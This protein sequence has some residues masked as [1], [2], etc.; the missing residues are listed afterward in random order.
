[1]FEGPRGRLIAAALLAVAGLGVYA[2]SLHGPFVFDDIYS[3]VEDPSLAHLWPPFEARSGSGASGRPLV[4]LTLKLNHALGGLEVHGYHLLNVVLHVLTSWTLFGFARRALART[5]LADVAAGTGF[6]IALL[7]TVHPL[8]SD[9]LN[10]VV[11][12]SEVLLGLF[13]LLTLYATDRALDAERP[14]RW[15]VLG[16]LACA[17]AMASKEIA[18]SLP[19]AALA[20]ERTF[21]SGSFSASWRARRGYYLGLGATWAVLGL[22]LG[23]AERGASVGFGGELSSLDYLR[24]QAGGLLHYLRLSFW[25]VGLSADYFGWAPVRSWGPALAP[26]LVVAFL[27]TLSL[28]SFLKGRPAGWVGLVALAIL[29]PSSSFL[30]I[31][32]EWL[33]EHRMYLPLAAVVALAVTGLVLLLRGVAPK[34]AGLVGTALCVLAAIPLALMT[35]GRNTTWSDAEALWLDTLARY[36]ENARAHDSLAVLYLRS[37][38]Y[39][40]AEAAAREAQRLAPQLVA[41]D[42][43]LATALLM[44]DRAAEALPYY[45]RAR[46]HFDGDPRFHA[47]YGAALSKTPRRAE[48]I[49][50]LRRAL[51]QAPD[52]AQAHR[53]LA[54]T[55]LAEDRPLEALPHL[56]RLLELAPDPWAISTTIEL[57]ASHPDARVRNGNEALR[58]AERL[59]Q[60]GARDAKAL[61]LYAMSLAEVGRFEEAVGAVS[62]AIQAAPPERPKLMESLRARRARYAERQPFR[63]ATSGG[64]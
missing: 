61:D 51:A 24:T 25:P 39:A 13:Y 62:Q 46:R 42:Y 58:Y 9:A 3:I 35:R 30:P 43:N 4:A 45:E 18:V 48:A 15:Q 5:G 36:P 38:R 40:E 23:L 10:L 21:A 49:P 7:W 16:V 33:A 11:T 26:G 54:I 28:L 44:Q 53:N 17:A 52:Y 22:S 60:S 1:M 41:V 14:A 32:G 29:A 31:T 55:L 63:S 6:A 27:A 8:A 56:R 47:N 64:E 34:R 59:M 37:G 19:L 57:L 12:R 50:H 2:N 20:Y